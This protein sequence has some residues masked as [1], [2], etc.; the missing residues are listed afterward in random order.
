MGSPAVAYKTKTE[1]AQK[2][3]RKQVVVD[4]A[5]DA[6][7]QK[8]GKLTA[9]IVLEAATPESHPLH[10]FFEWNDSKAA[11]QHRMAQA[12][13]LIQASKFVALLKE[14]T[15]TPSGASGVE[16]RRFVS[17]FSGEGFVARREALDGVNSRKAVIERKISTLRGWCREASDIKELAQIRNAVQ[18]AIARFTGE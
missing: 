15:P 12:Y 18:A 6:L 11:E 17:P 1:V 14:Q 8:K 2:R 9:A 7:Y 3:E 13:A 16:V 5:L 4:K 10:R